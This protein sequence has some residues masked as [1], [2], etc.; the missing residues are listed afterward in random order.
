MLRFMPELAGVAWRSL[1][2][3]GVRE[4]C[5]LAAALGTLAL[6]GCSKEG[7]YPD[8]PI[9]LICPWAAGGGTDLVS[10]QTAAVLERELGVPVNVVNATG[11]GGVT[12]HTRGALARPDGYTITMVTVEINMLH[13]RGLTNISYRDYDPVGLVNV[14]PAALFVR[15]DAPWEDLAAFQEHVQADPSQVKASGTANGGIWHLAFAGW[16]DQLGLDPAAAIWLPNNGSSPSLQELI[17][18]GIDVVCCSL[19]EAQPLLESDR[20]RCLGVMADERVAQFPEVPT[21]KEQGI[22]WTMTAWR[23][24]CV[25]AGTPPEV[26]ARLTEALEAV[27]LSETFQRL[28]RESGFNATWKPG[29]EYRQ[30]MQDVDERLGKLLDSGSLSFGQMWLGPMFF[31]AVLG[32][33]MAMVLAILVAVGGLRR[34]EGV[35]RVTPRGLWRCLEFVAWV[36]LYVLVAEA[37]GFIITSTILLVYSLWRVGNRV[38]VAVIVSAVVVPLAYQ[39]FAVW[40]RVPLPRGWLGW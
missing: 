33:L 38:P 39:L 23:G 16:L 25:P 14:D 27:A 1:S 28:M 10:R 30:Y 17:A 18:G 31:P 12:G 22:D 34:G 37:V 3:T 32:V 2:G 26:T 7:S 40:L 21:L 4:C 6:A 29:P 36:L 35:E 11:G 13:W 24:I 19:P 15:S 8:R 5:V 20:V 9:V